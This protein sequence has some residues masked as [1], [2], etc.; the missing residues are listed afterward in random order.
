[1][2]TK[3]D[4]QKAFAGESQ[5]NRKYLAY[6][7]AAELEGFKHIAKLFFAAAEAETVHALAHFRVMEGTKSTKE[8]LQKA[9]E[10]ESVEA[11]QMYPKFIEQAQKEGVKAAENSFKNA[12][13]VE[14]VHHS[15]FNQALEHLKEGKDLPEGDFYV[16]SVCG[17]TFFKDVPD[18][19][20]VCESSRE[21][22]RKTG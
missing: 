19:C 12:M 14:V 2:S 5:A 7:K 16:C 22:F 21:K 13:A 15:L 10:G 11:Q 6:S 17:N 8:N 1:M 20:P 18:K 4:L 9:V 3:D